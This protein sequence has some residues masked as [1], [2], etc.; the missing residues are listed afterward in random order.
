MEPADSSAESSEPSFIEGLPD[1]LLMAIFDQCYQ[2]PVYRQR[3]L[4]NIARVSS[5][6][7]PIAQERLLAQPYLQV[8]HIDQLML[9]YKRRP[10]IA[11]KVTTLELAIRLTEASCS[12]HQQG[13]TI[14]EKSLQQVAELFKLL[15]QLHTILLGSSYLKS[16][17]SLQMLLLGPDRLLCGMHGKLLKN[18]ACAEASGN[19]QAYAQVKQRLRVLELPIEWRNYGPFANHEAYETEWDLSD[20][21]SFKELVTPQQALFRG[22]YPNIRFL[23]TLPQSLEKLTVTTAENLSLVDLMRSLVMHLPQMALPQLK[24]IEIWSLSR[25]PDPSMSPPDLFPWLA[26]TAK[27]VSECCAQLTTLGINTLIH[28]EN[29]GWNFMVDM[30]SRETGENLGLDE[31]FRTEARGIF[32]KWRVATNEAQRRSQELWGRRRSCPRRK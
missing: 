4:L 24:T 26:G 17:L 16:T 13:P 22:D 28:Y 11:A 32:E 14:F 12:C 25:D 27:I 1:D 10:V 20:Y 8:D 30:G 21:T 15:P 7:A 18:T 19:S 3:N 6:F 5:R 9:A 29:E 23:G 2:R 31:Y